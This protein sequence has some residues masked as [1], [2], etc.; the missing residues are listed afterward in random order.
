M[1]SSLYC[2]QWMQ[3]SGV[4]KWG[5]VTAERPS[6][7]RKTHGR[8]F[9]TIWTK[10]YARRASGVYEMQGSALQNHL[11]AR[12]I[13]TYLR[14]NHS[15]KKFLAKKTFYASILPLKCNP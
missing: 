10:N 14:F 15:D 12:L 7:P 13:G 2:G 6:K 3:C 11:F 9:K 1:N 8:P 4:K 5:S